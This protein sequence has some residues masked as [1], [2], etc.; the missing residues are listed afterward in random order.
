MSVME[1]TGVDLT[2]T[3][4]SCKRSSADN[5]ILPHSTK[6][7]RIVSSMSQ[8]ALHAVWQ[9]GMISS[10]S[11]NS[12]TM[13]LASN[14]KVSLAQA[15]RR[16]PSLR[17]VNSQASSSSGNR[18]L[19]VLGNGNNDLSKPPS[20]GLGMTETK[21]QTGSS[22]IRRELRADIS[23]S[24]NN[25]NM[26]SHS[27]ESPTFSRGSWARLSD[28][29]RQ[30]ITLGDF[31]VLGFDDDSSL[32]R[33]PSDCSSVNSQ[34]KSL[35]PL[36]VSSLLK[37]VHSRLRATIAATIAAATGNPSS[38][39]EGTPNHSRSLASSV[40]GQ[41]ESLTSGKKATL[42]V[43]HSASICGSCDTKKKVEDQPL[44]LSIQSSPLKREAL[45]SLPDMSEALSPHQIS[46]MAT[47]DSSYDRYGS[48]MHSVQMKD[49]VECGGVIEISGKSPSV[50][51]K[52]SY[53]SYPEDSTLTASKLEIKSRPSYLDAL[54]QNGL[55]L[56][57]SPRLDEPLDLSVSTAKSSASPTVRPSI[58][59]DKQKNASPFTDQELVAVMAKSLQ[60]Y[61]KDTPGKSP[62]PEREGL[63]LTIEDLRISRENSP[64]PYLNKEGNMWK[65][66]SASSLFHDSSDTSPAS[67][68]SKMN[69]TVS[70]AR[71]EA[72]L[73]PNALKQLEVSPQTTASLKCASMSRNP[74]HKDERPTSHGLKCIMDSYGQASCTSPLS[75]KSQ[76]SKSDETEL[77]CLTNVD[78]NHRSSFDTIK[79]T[80]SKSNEKRCRR[81][82]VSYGQDNGRKFFAEA[83]ENHHHSFESSPGQGLST[84]D[85]DLS[86][87]HARR[88]GVSQTKK[89]NVHH[90]NFPLLQYSK[91]PFN[92]ESNKE[93]LSSCLDP[94]AQGYVSGLYSPPLC[95][96]ARSDSAD[97]SIERNLDFDRRN[98]YDLSS[99]QKNVYELSVGADM[100][101][102]KKNQSINGDGTMRKEVMKK[103]L[104]LEN[105]A[106]DIL[107]LR[108]SQIPHSHHN[109][110]GSHGS[111]S[112]LLI[113]GD[114]LAHKQSHGVS[115]RQT[116]KHQLLHSQPQPG[117]F[118]KNVSNVELQ[119]SAKHV[120]DYFSHAL[121][122]EP[123]STRLTNSTGK[124]KHDI[125]HNRSPLQ[126][127]DNAQ[128]FSP[129][130]SSYHKS[131]TRSRGMYSKPPMSRLDG[132][133]M[134][135]GKRDRDLL[136]QKLSFDS[137]QS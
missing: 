126:Q 88:T 43:N 103:N 27:S 86:F 85:L 56:Y 92:K 32:D 118:Y 95:A 83:I 28:H 40:S 121:A 45:S 25:I 131:L 23:A 33:R 9:S 50:F 20:Q 77:V 94:E 104:I 74:K 2:H 81:N 48:E 123:Y 10:S 39:S 62:N 49:L 108:H 127:L 64:E 122:S 8:Q 101:L 137:E 12:S 68:A 105:Q 102:S 5:K 93:V 57:S 112:D 35:S 66:R 79:K 41:E 84:K 91:S 90:S 116:T 38:S 115:L 89:L 16:T 60:G 78:N 29:N 1:G 34:P 120:A 22:E 13:S 17:S 110:P 73:S 133:L 11:S 21:T 31:T 51:S 135:G 4:S 58:K 59:K 117:Y 98:S 52:A 71:A 76:Y 70:V 24:D 61:L 119:K 128:H 14:V 75:S 106:S 19:P 111:Q 26:H 30:S 3:A 36:N 46:D 7:S 87:S 67:S 109:C 132:E 97:N 47:T 69:R 99:V 130:T 136:R 55:D 6:S 72:K 63:A 37:D 100:E 134:K 129:G 53:S 96:N 82:D 114:I 65:S 113:T 18:L 15:G 124:K 80:D 42:S 125:H 107:H 54:T 44:N